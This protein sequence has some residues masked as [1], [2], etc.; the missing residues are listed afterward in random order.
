M[1]LPDVLLIEATSP[2]SCCCCCCASWQVGSALSDP[3]LSFAAGMTGLAGPLHGLANQ[4]VL[5]WINDTKHQVGELLVGWGGVGVCGGGGGG[6]VC[7]WGGVGCGV[8]GAQHRLL[9]PSECK[10]E[11]NLLA[12][13]PVRKQWH[14]KLDGGEERGRCSAWSLPVV[15]VAV[16]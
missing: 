14:D 15:A 16:L 3:Y 8:G 6:G 1:A 12:R 4:E 13:Q 2:P 11:I 5:R 7:V 10:E 9:S